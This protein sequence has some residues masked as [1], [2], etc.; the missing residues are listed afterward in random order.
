MVARWETLRT[1]GHVTEAITQPD[2][3]SWLNVYTNTLATL[4]NVMAQE[5]LTWTISSAAARAEELAQMISKL[6]AVATSINVHVTAVE[7]R[8]KKQRK[9]EKTDQRR[10]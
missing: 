3:A 6:D 2:M 5:V 8:V 7:E 4:K 10:A 1:A 9:A